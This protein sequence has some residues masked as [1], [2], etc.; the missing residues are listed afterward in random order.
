[1]LAQFMAVENARTIEG[2]GTQSLL[3]GGDGAGGGAAAEAGGL[4]LATP[5]VGPPVSAIDNPAV[6]G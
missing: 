5:D 2:V 3:T 6:L 4:E 1:M